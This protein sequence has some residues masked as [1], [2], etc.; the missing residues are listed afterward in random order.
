MAVAAN[1]PIELV[2]EVYGRLD[3]RIALARRRLGRPL[4]LAEKIL[5]NHLAD[6]EGQDLSKGVA[7]AELYPDRVAMQ[8]A[9]AQMALLQFMTA[10]LPQV[11]VP[12]TVKSS[13]RVVFP[14]AR[15][16]SFVTAALGANVVFPIP[17]PR[18]AGVTGAVRLAVTLIVPTGSMIGCVLANAA[19]TAAVSSVAPSAVMPNRRPG[20]ASGMTV[21]ASIRADPRPT[22]CVASRARCSATSA[23][24]SAS[25]C[26]R[27]RFGPP[28][29]G[30]TGCWPAGSSRRPP[31][32]R[33][34]S[35]RGLRSEPPPGG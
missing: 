32:R 33:T 7:Y 6:P 34:P 30:S 26:P 35:S 1:T 31:R 18:I 29:A 28:C 16:N 22:G 23:H 17:I 27:T 5:I 2:N 12:S 8:D 9:T 25:C 14:A 3:E 4:S 11:A 21:A 10:G 20:R 19:L 15:E 13:R 24:G